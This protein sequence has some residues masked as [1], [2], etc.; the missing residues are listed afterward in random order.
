[1]NELYREVAVTK[2]KKY[3]YEEAIAHEIQNY[4]DNNLVGEERF[5]LDEVRFPTDINGDTRV[6][7]HLYR[8]EFPDDY[9]DGDFPWCEDWLKFL[10]ELS[11]RLGGTHVN[12]P[13]YYYPK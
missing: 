8:Q 11:V 3:Y 5:N 2:I 4:L 9:I 12:T 6:E 13:Y 1:M 7:I 10:K